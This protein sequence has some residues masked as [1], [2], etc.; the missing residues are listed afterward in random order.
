MSDPAWQHP[1]LRIERVIP[2]V[3]DND[4]ISPGIS[5]RLT[6]TAR[7]AGERSDPGGVWAAGGVQYLADRY[8]GGDWRV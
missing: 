5:W 4:E 7:G 3:P 8:G 6:G 1:W 2:A